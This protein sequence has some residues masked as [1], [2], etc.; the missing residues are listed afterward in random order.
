MGVVM[1]NTKYYTK[2]ND[3]ILNK[4]RSLTVEKNLSQY[5]GKF[6]LSVSDPD[7]LYYNEFT[8]GD[9]IEVVE[10]Y[11][12]SPVEREQSY[13]SAHAINWYKFND[14]LDDSAGV[15]TPSILVRATAYYPFNGNANDE[16]TSGFNGV[17]TGATLTTD[18][19][20]N[21]HSAYAFTETPST[22]I[23]VPNNVAFNVQSLTLSCWIKTTDVNNTFHLR[24]LP[25]IC[26]ELRLRIANSEDPCSG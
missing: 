2:I 6:A 12:E 9:E 14:N 15:T 24:N 3:I 22:Y 11:I 4:V 25:L 21:E 1:S 10:N 5:S 20:G 8:S 19:F 16:S 18:R 17:V 7:N 23:T 26:S 13:A